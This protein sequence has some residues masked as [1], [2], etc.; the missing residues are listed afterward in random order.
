MAYEM[1]LEFQGNYELKDVEEARKLFGNWCVWVRTTREQTGELLKPMAPA[2]RM[3]GGHLEGNLAYWDKGLTNA[4]MDGLNSLFSAG[5]RK[6]RRY[7]KLVYITQNA[8]LHR[9]ETA[10]PSH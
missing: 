2:V 8:L 7:R 6:A 10:L 1:R 9:Q 4:F 3:I 5:T